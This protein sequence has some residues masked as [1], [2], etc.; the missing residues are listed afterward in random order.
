M[1]FLAA[2]ITWIFKLW[3][4]SPVVPI[5]GPPDIGPKPAPAPQ[6][7]RALITQ[8]ER[9][10]ARFHDTGSPAWI[11]QWKGTPME[12][13]HGGV[14]FSAP[15]GSP[16]YA[17]YPMRV[18]AVGYYPDSGRKGYY[19]I[20][21]LSDGIE[22]YSGHLMA[23]EVVAN[24]DVEGGAVIGHTNE[25][26]HTHIQMKRGGVLIDPETYLATH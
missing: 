19:V 16:V 13:Q 23:L 15:P 7:G 24:S 17:P 5:A 14:D 6:T 1:S 25:Y 2:I 9:I 22:Y 3:G 11:N 10:S 26:A 8:P 12:G 21:K 18:I 4:Q 20:G